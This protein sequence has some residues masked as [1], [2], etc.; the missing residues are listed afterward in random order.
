[1]RKT[2]SSTHAVFPVPGLP[3]SSTLLFLL[4]SGKMPVENLTNSK[5]SRYASLTYSLVTLQE[6]AGAALT[7]V[8]TTG[9]GAR[10]PAPYAFAEGECEGGRQ[11]N[12]VIC[13]GGLP[14]YPQQCSQ[15]AILCGTH[16]ARWAWAGAQQL[17]TQAAGQQLPVMVRLSS[18]HTGPTGPRR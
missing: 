5:I 12:D 6:R 16:T 4:L 13:N 3:E 18:G 14:Q 9:A 2:A 8:L 1:M 7:Q 11:L 10:Q 15:F 17:L